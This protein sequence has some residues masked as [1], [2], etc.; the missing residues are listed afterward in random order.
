M[1]YSYN[2][3]D[4]W[5][6]ASNEAKVEVDTWYATNIENT[7]FDSYVVT[8][9]FCEQAKV[10]RTD[11]Y[12]GGNTEMVLYSNYTPNF[13][14][15]TDGNGYGELNLKVGLIT[16]DEV[17]FAGG[18]YFKDNSSFYLKKL[19]NESTYAYMG[20]MSPSGKSGNNGTIWYWDRDGAVL[21]STSNYKSYY[22]PVINIDGSLPATGNGEPGSEYELI[23]N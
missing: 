23:L 13:R 10:K 9:K 16:Y 7:V 20:I 1:Y 21:S 14:C 12:T 4:Y 11:S 15:E 19:Y 22:F 5:G 17:I 8:G 6:V 2:L 3:P 18:Y